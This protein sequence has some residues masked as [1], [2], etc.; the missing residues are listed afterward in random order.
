MKTPMA[1]T[2][3]SAM[4]HGL[5][6]I[7]YKKRQKSVTEL[8]VLTVTARKIPSLVPPFAIVTVDSPASDVMKMST[9]VPLTNVSITPNVWIKSMGMNATV[10]PAGKA[11]IA[12]LTSTNVPHIWEHPVKMEPHVSTSKV[13]TNASALTDGAGKIATKIL[14]IV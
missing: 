4:I 10:N 6:K 7:V 3:A 8:T 2:R 11:D 13:T 9:T 14:T 1:D 5:G 12:K